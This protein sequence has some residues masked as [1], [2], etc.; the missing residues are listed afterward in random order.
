MA[1]WTPTHKIT[2]RPVQGDPEET[3]VALVEGVAYTIEEWEAE[4]SADWERAEDGSWL[5]QG[6]AAPGNGTVEVEPLGDMTS[7]TVGHRVTMN[8]RWPV[9]HLI[10]R[11]YGRRWGL[12]L[13]VCNGTGD[14]GGTYPSRAAAIRAALAAAGEA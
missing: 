14:R 8:T 11:G 7:I 10:R 5:F 9:E 13:F 3:I 12:S 4:S 1:Q 2:F 6:Q